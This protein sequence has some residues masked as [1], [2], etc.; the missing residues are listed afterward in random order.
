MGPCGR[1]LQDL[2][3][4]ASAEPVSRRT[5]CVKR[6]AMLP[7]VPRDPRRQLGEKASCAHGR[8]P[9]GHTHAHA[10]SNETPLGCPALVGN[11]GPSSLCRL[12]SI[13]QHFLTTALVCVLVS[14]L[15]LIVPVVLVIIALFVGR[16]ALVILS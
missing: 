2:D 15:M 1:A 3:R 6:T 8:R 16:L 10:L 5:V 12:G 9:V 13:Q 4:I 14:V 7:E 11:I